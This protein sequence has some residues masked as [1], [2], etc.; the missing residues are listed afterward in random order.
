[1]EKY[2]YF[3][4]LKQDVKDY[5]TNEEDLFIDYPDRDELFEHLMDNLYTAD[6]VTGNGSGSYF[7]NTYKAEEAIA[8]NWDL[9]SDALNAFEEEDVNIIDKGAEWCDVT[10]RCYLLPQVINE[11]LDEYDNRFDSNYNES[12][13]ETHYNEPI[14]DYGDNNIGEIKNVPEEALIYEGEEEVD[15][16]WLEKTYNVEIDYD[17]ENGPYTIK[18]YIGRLEDFFN[19]HRL[20]DYNCKKTW[21]GKLRNES[22]KEDKNNYTLENWLNDNSDGNYSIKS[23]ATFKTL[24]D[25]VYCDIDYE[26]EF[27]DDPDL[28]NDYINGG[29]ILK[30]NC[31]YIPANTEVKFVVGQ[32]IDDYVI[33]KTGFDFNVAE[34]YEEAL[35]I[36][37]ENIININESGYLK[38]YTNGKELVDDAIKYAQDD[39]D[40]GEDVDD[41][42]HM[43][44]DRVCT[45]SNNVLL[46]AKYYG[47]LD[48]NELIEKFGDNLYN[49]IYQTVK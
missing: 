32:S 10:I 38:N 24:K 49:D 21:C 25:M 13:K 18:G 44:I 14:I 1:M 29:F 30:D 8:H 20:F 27:E 40:N 7:F 3:K 4:E 39:I 9:L 31:L 5:I 22:L 15:I 46:L 41:A 28:I 36:P 35:D 19:D 16:P 6:S 43:A 47:V 23:G 33:V 45:Y 42:I 12:L 34:W 11:V 17:S 26:G 48:D 37:V 2:D